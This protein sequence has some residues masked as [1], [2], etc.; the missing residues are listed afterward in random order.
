MLPE[1]EAPE[2]ED[3]AP[4][5]HYHYTPPPGLV[6][7]LA[8][9]LWNQAYRPMDAAVVA[10]S[11]IVMAGICGRQFQIRGTGLNLYMMVLSR[12]GSGK[13]QMSLGTSKL[14]N[15]LIQPPRSV[16]SDIAIP[17]FEAAREFQG[18][19]DLTGRGLERVIAEHKTHSCFSVFGE[20]AYKLKSM[21]AENANMG[22]QQLQRMLLDLFMKSAEGSMYMGTKTGDKL[23]DTPPINSPA[24]S[25]LCESTPLNVYEVLDR[26]LIASGL[27]P[28]F[29]VLENLKPTVEND[30][31]E[32]Y[33]Q[34]PERLKGQ[35]QN[36][37]LRVFDLVREQD[38]RQQVVFANKAY[39]KEF[40]R[41]CEYKRSHGD[42]RMAE[43][44]TRCYINTVRVAGLVAI[45]VDWTTPTITNEI[46]DWA[47]GL[48]VH[49]IEA[50]VRKFEKGDTGT[51]DKRNIDIDN[52]QTK[53]YDHM[54][55]MFRNYLAKRGDQ[56]DLARSEQ[57]ITRAYINLFAKAAT[58][59]YQ[60][61]SGVSTAVDLVLKTMEDEG[62]IQAVR[63]QHDGAGKAA[64]KAYKIIRP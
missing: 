12:T 63:L 13:E 14:F 15:S 47:R 60:H 4:P 39:A 20:F 25:L 9:W 34:P 64:G 7:E 24:F 51:V 28:R 55:K 35:I 29:I 26:S 19:A 16:G 58:K 44:W 5:I 36:L 10:S 50:M 40:E 23:K 52:E 17:G 38:Q 8:V 45:G 33:L 59:H 11:L 30:I 62:K 43:L 2:P 27:L 57:I 54:S 1:P 48:V 37:M 6:G 18:P 46:L 49:S 21:C 32:Q 3:E 31:Y 56:Y 53:S 41:W 22:D 42:E 61:R